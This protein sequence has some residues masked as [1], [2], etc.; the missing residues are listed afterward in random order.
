MLDPTLLF[1]DYREITGTIKEKDEILCYKL[2]RNKDFFNHIGTI[3][4]KMGKP[5]RLL[6]HIA[7]VKGLR[8]TYPPGV[9]EWISHIAGAAFVVT[10]SFHG[11]AFSLIYHRQFAVVRCHDGRDSRFEDLLKELGLEDKV[12][13]TIEELAQSECWKKTIDYTVITPKLIEIRKRSWDFLN[14]SLNS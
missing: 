9:K 7:P 14:N 5:A 8:Y 4:K 11:L 6:N 10:D 3:K 2:K 12:F 1:D 13:D